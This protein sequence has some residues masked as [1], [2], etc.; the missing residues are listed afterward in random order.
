MYWYRR[1]MRDL[2]CDATDTTSG[3]P[4]NNGS[5]NYFEGRPDGWQT[6]D[7][8]V[9][10]AS[11]LTQAGAITVN[12]GGQTKTENAPAGAHIFTVPMGLGQQTFSLSRGGSTVLSGT[13]LM[14][15]SNVCPCGIYNFNAYVGSL[16]AGFNDPL[17]PDGLASLTAGLHVTTCQATPSL[18]TNPPITSGSNPPPPTTSTPN[19][20]P[21][22]SNPPTSNPPTSN[23]PTSKPPTSTQPPGGGTF[24][25]P[26]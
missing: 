7:D 20:P 23:P 15:I 11:F 1:T 16:P 14:D 24:A 19:Q 17:G 13:S 8:V 3:R 2:D 12:S 25:A 21:P 10:V 26:L 18:G 6:M 4:A 22:T 5:G 9:Y